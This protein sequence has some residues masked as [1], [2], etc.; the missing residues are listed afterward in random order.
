M[1]VN[2]R[3]KTQSIIGWPFIVSAG[4]VSTTLR[5]CLGLESKRIGK[6]KAHFGEIPPCILRLFVTWK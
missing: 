1:P 2:V 5:G 3:R 6:M 4:I